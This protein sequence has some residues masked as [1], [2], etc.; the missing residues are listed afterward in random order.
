MSRARGA[1][2][3]LVGVCAVWGVTFVMVQ[4]AVAELPVLSFLAWRFL[5]AAA[6]VAV[7]FRRRLR[8]LGAAGL[9]AG[10]LM[11]AF[12][13]TGYVLQTFA[14]QHT[15]AS[16]VGFLTGLFTPFTPLLAALIL[17]APLGRTAMAAAVTATAGVALLSGVGGE[18]HLLGDG[19]ALACAIAFS[20]HILATD[21]GVAGHDVGALLAVQLATCGA[22]SLV[23]AALTGDLEAPRGDTVWSA[24]VVT[25]V[26][27]SAVAF[28]VQ[29]AAQRYATP[30][31]TA[32]ILATEPA[33]AGLFGWLLAGDRLTAAGW[34]G[35][36]LIL[37]AI[38]AVDLVPRLRPP[39]PLPEG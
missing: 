2:L 39:R 4:D 27:A 33:F 32:L 25:A 6:L 15:S 12:L 14:L 8:A 37:A 34:V 30:A 3:A 28:F 19:L 10:L 31:R 7:L 36:A 18:L 29:S 24:L 11:G 5:A 20:I 22:V 1:E 16:N 17:S 35:A 9:R 21:R 38:L 13:T 26:V 23:A